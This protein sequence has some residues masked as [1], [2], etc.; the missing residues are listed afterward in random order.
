MAKAYCAG[1]GGLADL[2]AAPLSWTESA[3]QPWV[4]YRTSEG[5]PTWRR[6][7][8][9]VSDKVSADQSG[10]FIGFRCAK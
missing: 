5:R 6:D 7:D 4:E 3:S 1:R 8:G 9:G 10:V 2:A